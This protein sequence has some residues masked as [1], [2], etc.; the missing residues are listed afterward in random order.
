MTIHP[1]AHSPGQT[2]SPTE[3]D[4]GHALLAQVVLQETG[5]IRLNL[6]GS[7]ELAELSPALQ[8]IVLQHLISTSIEENFVGDD[9]TTVF[10]LANTP[11][12]GVCMVFKNGLLQR[13]DSYTVVGT[14]VTFLVAPLTGDHIQIRYAT[15]TTASIG[16]LGS[17]QIDYRDITEMAATGTALFVYG[18]NKSSGLKEVAKYEFVNLIQLG[19]AVNVDSGVPDSTIMAITQDLGVTYLWAVGASSGTNKIVKINTT[20]MSSVEIEVTVDTAAEIV[21]LV[22]DGAYVYA[23]QKGGTVGPNAVAKIDAVTNVVTGFAAATGASSTG[24]V[25]MV[26]GP[27]GDLYIAIGNLNSTG[28]GEVRRYDLGTGTLVTTFDFAETPPNP[29]AAHPIK[30]GVTPTDVLVLDDTR[31]KFYTIDMSDGVTILSPG[32]THFAFVP[33]DMLV[34]GV[35][36]LWITS[37]NT[38]YEVSSAGAVLQSS[39]PEPTLTLQDLA[40]GAGLLWASYSDDTGAPDNNISKLFPGLPG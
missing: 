11:D 31:Q 32:T 29:T 8:A 33:S 12:V 1:S 7:L 14:A 6:R 19:T 22:T 4:R 36:D 25:D 18:T 34:N 37:G 35:T 27:N 38:L 17:F 24:A 2:I 20:D 9:V 26:I 13:A 3:V 30:L 39:T 40:W 15:S 28:I 5:A 21:S 16:H 10:N 23:F